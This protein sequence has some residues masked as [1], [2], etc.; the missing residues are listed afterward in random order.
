MNT[1]PL[2][3]WSV[4]GFVTLLALV[5]LLYYLVHNEQQVTKP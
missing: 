2:L 1:F 5:G 3:Y 4:G